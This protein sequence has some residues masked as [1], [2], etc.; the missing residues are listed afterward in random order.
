MEELWYK[1]II[2]CFRD[3]L[4]FTFPPRIFKLSYDPV[5]LF[6]GRNK[7]KERLEKK[8]E[9]S[10]LLRQIPKKLTKKVS[11]LLKWIC[12]LLGSYYKYWSYKCFNPYFLDQPVVNGWKF[13]NQYYVRNLFL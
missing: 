3:Y 9:N 2:I 1:V 13:S 5:V 8:K 11:I 12:V 10:D 7:V 4:T 6:E